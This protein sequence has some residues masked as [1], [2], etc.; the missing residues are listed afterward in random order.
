VGPGQIGPYR[1]LETLGEGA[2]GVVYRAVDG[3]GTE[4]ALKVI[5]PEMTRDEGSRK[6]LAHEIRALRELRHANLVPLL[7]AGEVD[8]TSFIAFAYLA[9][10]ETLSGRLERSGVLEP[11]E[12]VGVARQ[13]GSAL[14]AMH[15][16]GMVHRDV[17]PSNVILSG[18]EA[19][20]S[21]LGLVR[22]AGYTAL[23]RP[24]R[25]LGT[26]DYLAPELI[27]GET[28]GPASDLYALGCTLYECA[29]GTPPFGGR[30]MLAVGIAHLEEQPPDPAATRAE[31]SP[32][33]CSALLVALAKEPSERPVSARD[34]AEL[35]EAAV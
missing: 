33:F 7:D 11:A 31:L 24:G 4:V 12:I 17:K 18:D 22:G 6:R 35:L 28:A 8:G 1:T 15:E 9:G 32:A 3:E 14:D 10:S 19:L 26:A 34:Y 23:T 29:V 13:I 16:A 21:D 27:R 2:A 25:V 30:S 20:L 5:R